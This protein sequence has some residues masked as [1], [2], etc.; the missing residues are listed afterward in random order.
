MNA[1]V[2]PDMPP[3]KIAKR[4]TTKEEVEA[5]LEELEQEAKKVIDAMTKFWGNIIQD[6]QLKKL[7]KQL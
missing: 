3:E 7:T 4:K 5:Q 2:Y 6:E 1:L